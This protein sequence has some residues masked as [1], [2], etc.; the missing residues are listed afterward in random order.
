M[1]LGYFDLITPEPLIVPGVGSLKPPTLR[2]ISRLTYPVYETYLAFLNMSPARYCTE[3]NPRFR[4]WYEAL[5]TEQAALLS[6]YDIAVSNEELAKLFASIFQFFFV[7][8]VLYDKENDAF[9][10][11]SENTNHGSKAAASVD[12]EEPLRQST[13][14]G[15]ITKGVYP[16][17]VALI[18]KLNHIDSKEP[19]DLSKVKNE[20]GRKIYQRI[21]KLKEAHVRTAKKNDDLEIG[22]IISA[23]CTRHHSI[24]Y[25]NVWD[26]TVYQL[27]DTFHRLQAENAY[28][29]N[30]TMVSVWGDKEK[31]FDFNSWFKN[32]VAPSNTEP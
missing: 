16:Q 17:I 10:L 15:R 1:Q 25:T 21:Q 31:K 29:I 20:K 8:Q 5:P 24:N 9:L 23:V 6:M 19:V 26:L 4:D 11:L 32:I 13:P 18:L 14:C 3:V 2:D 30:K 7:E 12:S 27:W 28:E 22:N